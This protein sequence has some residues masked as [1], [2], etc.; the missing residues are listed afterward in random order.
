MAD[1]ETLKV[2][3]D[4]YEVMLSASCVEYYPGRTSADIMQPIGICMSVL[5]RFMDQL[6]PV[7]RKRLLDKI[8]SDLMEARA[9]QTVTHS[10]NS[11]LRGNVDL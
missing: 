10:T 5:Y 3:T 8:I 9:S 6:K 11:L 4:A 7:Q 2:L 1:E